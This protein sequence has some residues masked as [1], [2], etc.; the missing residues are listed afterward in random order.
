MYMVVIEVY[1][2]ES[3]RTGILWRTEAEGGRQM[4]AEREFYFH[5]NQAVLASVPSVIQLYT[6]RG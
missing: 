5:G 1:A 2:S 3:E 4:Q 6:D